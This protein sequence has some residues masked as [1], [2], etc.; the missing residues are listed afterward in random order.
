MGKVA[1]TLEIWTTDKSPKFD[2]YTGAALADMDIKYQNIKVVTSGWKDKPNTVALVCG[3]DLFHKFNEGDTIAHLRGSV[4]PGRSTESYRIYTYSPMDKSVS[5]QGK[6]SNLF[7]ADLTKQATWWY[8]VQKAGRLMEYG[9]TPM[10]ENFTWATTVEEVLEYTEYCKREKPLLA[11]DLETVGRDDW[12]RPFLFG[13]AD[14]ETTGFCVPL[15]GQDRK[16]Y[17][18]QGD[19][20]IVRSCLNTILQNC[21]Q[22]YQ[23]A[24]FDVKVLRQ[25]GYEFPLGNVLHDTMLLHHTL[26]SALPHSLDFITSVYGMTPYWKDTLKQNPKALISL[27][28]EESVPYNLRD[29]VVLHQILPKMLE[30]L[31]HEGLEDIYRNEAMAD[32]YPALEQMETGIYLS[33]TA[34]E[35]WKKYVNIER[36]SLEKELRAI[37]PIPKEFNLHS[38]DHIGWLV[39]NQPIAKFETLGVLDDYEESPKQAC[40]CSDCNKKYWAQQGA[41]PPICTKCGSTSFFH[42]EEHKVTP[43]KKKLNNKGE[44]SATYKKLLVLKEISEIPRMYEGV[45]KIKISHKTGKHVLDEKERQKLRFDAQKWYIGEDAKKRKNHKNIAGLKAMVHWLEVYD[46][47]AHREK[48]RSTY[49]SFPRGGDGKMHFNIKLHGTETGRPAASDVNILNQ[50]TKKEKLL[51]DCYVAPRGWK[52]VSM[53]YS[54]LEA[55]VVAYVVQDPVFIAAVEGGNLHDVNTRALFGIDSTDDLWKPARGAAKIFQF[56]RIQYG[57]GREIYEKIVLAC[58]A[59]N[60]S[61]SQFETLTDNYFNNYKVFGEWRLKTADTALST[62]KSYTAFG[63]LR[64]LYGHSHQIVK[65]AYNFPGQGTAA[66]VMNRVMAQALEARDNAGFRA[67]LQVQIYDDLRWLC[68]EEEVDDLIKVVKPIMQ[69]PFDIFGTERSFPTDVEVGNSWGDLVDLKKLEEEGIDL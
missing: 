33:E 41:F 20:V 44:V 29:C 69:Q 13:M 26:D 57:G 49:T 31:A 32:I 55:R 64:N 6:I 9:Y 11:I 7:S 52:V 18:S 46:K 48:Q 22:I 36:V 47:W 17:W 38:M 8:D 40:R 61:Y 35:A 37:W 53:D 4:W 19:E 63:R 28:L 65:Q 60:L 59:L 5:A 23:N 10:E 54:N 58:P 68:P 39:A 1:L 16:S 15:L 12:T 51:G 50:P 43:K 24:L 34:I 67:K 42:L 45:F 3:K 62:R 2:R 30:E 66:G 25:N 21:P 27:P 14:S 56:G